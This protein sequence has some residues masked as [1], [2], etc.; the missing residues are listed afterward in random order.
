MKHLLVPTDFSENAEH[1]YPYAL[2]IAAKTGSRVTFWLT[3]EEPFDFATRVEEKMKGIREYA[4]TK[5]EKMISEFNK[6]DEYSALEIDYKVVKGKMLSGILKGIHKIKPDWVIMGTKGSTG[7]KKIL[8]GSNASR[9]VSESPVPV[10]VIPN[11]S[12]FD[13]FQKIVFTT[14]YQENDLE[15]LHSIVEFA[16]LWNSTIRVLH[17]SQE[18]NLKS[19]IMQRGFREMIQDQINYKKLEFNLEYASNFL[20]GITGY[21]APGG[22]SLL[23][24]GRYDLDFLNQ[25]FDYSETKAM[26]F[27]SQTPLLVLPANN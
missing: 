3:V 24:M 11:E 21:Q 25:I 17:V 5:F 23:A 9:V 15:L 13:E 8:F 14:E 4:Q 10:L 27:Y 1:A 26:S 19:A 7:L 12:H 2:N 22:C 16:K 20:E 6:M 18:K